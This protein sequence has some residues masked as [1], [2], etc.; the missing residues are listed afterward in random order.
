MVSAY[1][2]IDI[3]MIYVSSMFLAKQTM[4]YKDSYSKENNTYK[5]SV[6]KK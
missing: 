2:T 5:N 4:I 3:V 1:R 6:V